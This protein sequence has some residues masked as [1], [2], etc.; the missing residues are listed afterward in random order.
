MYTNS[1]I[2]KACLKVI[3]PSKKEIRDY[4]ILHNEDEVGINNQ[5]SMEDAEHYLLASD[6]YY[7][8]GKEEEMIVKEGAEITNI[9]TKY[10]SED[11]EDGNYKIKT[12]K[13]GKMIEEL[14][15]HNLLI[16]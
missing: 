6:K 14:A 11:A 4:M 13:L 16:Q 5:W 2:K 3:G 10:I 15:K 8:K 1:E 9:L 12:G 7:Y